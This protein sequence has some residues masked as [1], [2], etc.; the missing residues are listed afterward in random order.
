MHKR[1]DFNVLTMELRLLCIKPPKLYVNSSYQTEHMFYH[2]DYI[3]NDVTVWRQILASLQSPIA[4]S[5]AF[6]HSFIHSSIHY[7]FVCVFVCLSV[8]ME[9]HA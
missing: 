6:I 1:H 5:S 4:F 9:D 8:R 3:G 7:L 2:L